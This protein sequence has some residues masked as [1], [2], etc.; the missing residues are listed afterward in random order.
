M[1]LCHCL[2]ADHCRRKALSKDGRLHRFEGSR[3]AS[4][5]CQQLCEASFDWWVQAH[6]HDCNHPWQIWYMLPKAGE[7]V[8]CLHVTLSC[9]LALSIACDKTCIQSVL[10][11]QQ[12]SPIMLVCADCKVA[13]CCPV[14]Y[15]SVEAQS[16]LS[17]WQPTACIGWGVIWAGWPGSNGS[18]FRCP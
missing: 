3:A 5:W 10:S 1:N 6:S 9:I 4:L 16:Q 14:P 8:C 12:T 17:I 13:S 11:M 18:W 7:P 2:A 15:R